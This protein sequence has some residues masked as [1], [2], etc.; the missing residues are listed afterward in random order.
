MYSNV[1]SWSQIENC[2]N[3]SHCPL[4]QRHCPRSQP[5][6]QLNHSAE[7]SE[8]PAA[9]AQLSVCRSRCQI[10]KAPRNGFAASPAA[11]ALEL[12]LTLENPAS[13]EGSVS[14]QVYNIIQRPNFQML[15]ISK[16]VQSKSCPAAQA[17]PPCSRSLTRSKHEK[18]GS[19][20]EKRAP[21]S[22]PAK[23]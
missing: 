4:D 18:T 10:S 19:L 15:H 23:S 3:T 20:R 5:Q 22:H 6:F 12:Q 7:V 9:K 11:F 14:W 8:P 16:R 1:Y 21:P 17:L 13:M 2:W